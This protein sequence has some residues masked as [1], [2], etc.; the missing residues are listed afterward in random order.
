[1]IKYFKFLIPLVLIS[2]CTYSLAFSQQQNQQQLISSYD[3]IRKIAPREKLYV[4]LDKSVY[5]STDTIWFKAYLVNTTSNGYSPLSGLIYTELIDA[6]GTVIQTICLPTS[7]GLTWGAFAL[8]EERYPPGK[9][10]FR[11]YT[12][13][14]RNFGST[15][16]YKKEIKILATVV[17]STVSE[18]IK[19]KPVTVNQVK[20]NE[21]ISD[22]IDFQLLP[23]GGTWIAGMR[24]KMAFKAV[25]PNGK[26]LEASGEIVDSKANKVTGF[27]S[28]AKGM[29]AFV[30]VPNG[31]ENYT[32]RIK[33]RYGTII[34]SLP[35][36]QLIGT[37]LNV[38]T[39]PYSDSL[40]IT[41]ASNLAGQDHTLIG[42]SKGFICFIANLKSDGKLSTIK[43][44]K[45]IFPTGVS[46]V[47]VMNNKKQILNE[48]SFFINLGDEL[49]LKTWTVA[50]QFGTRDSIPIYLKATDHLGKP[51]QGSFSMAI[52]DDGQVLKD[53]LN[54]ANILSY[55][56]L[57]S[58][59][60]GDIE[61]PG[62]Y[63]HQPENRETLND[64]DLLMLTQGWVSYH[65]DL[66]KIPTFKAEQDFTI[67]GS[68]TNVTNKPIAGAKVSLFGRNK[69]AIVMKD[70]VANAK[71][72]F[73]FDQF[74]L[75]DSASFV[76]QALNS[77]NKKGTLGITANEFTSPQ[78][79]PIN[80]SKWIKDQPLD[81]ISSQVVVV[82]NE[83]YQIAL[84]SGIALRE[85]KIVGKKT[86]KGS[87]NLH[88]PGTASQILTEEDL[89]P[90]A[91]KT[92]YDVL[93]EKIKG[94]REGTRPRSFVRDFLVNGDLARFVIDGVEVD[95][96]YS[97]TGNSTDEYYQYIRSYLDYYNAEDIKGIE[98]MENG[99]SFRYRSEFMHP[100][101]NNMYAFFEI[102][103]KTGSGPF[104]KKSANMYLIKPPAYGSNKVFYSPKYNHHNKANQTPDFR[105]TLYWNPNIITNEKG[106][107]NIS[108]FSA[109]KKG[110]YTVWLEGV[111][112]QG[113][114]GV[115]TM[116]IV[117][118]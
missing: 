37:A 60:K 57:S 118:K 53:T 10:T 65:W 27:S 17:G 97:P 39:Q 24:Q 115:S 92:L 36:T 9:Y 47:L 8:N 96:F 78:F 46:Q 45:H 95:F 29:G 26:G 75:L 117:I 112:T 68:I 42:Q 102:T 87:K 111:D 51:V 25:S 50:S 43:V 12:N 63:F 110:T 84:K 62:Y 73:V 48:R 104:L 21:K 91:K 98:T 116:K 99:Y 58:D 76:I 82:K 113:G 34:K 15:Y 18:S 56:L 64:L 19:S 3:T 85:V 4:H 35:K 54:E 101:D 106:E 59:L 105:S 13:W 77:K 38:N 108:F 55:L 52:T 81:S 30:M 32:A 2:I 74:P 11:A 114:L 100:L 1:M 61:D 79:V 5:L 86:I 70:T 7:L 94:F 31:E 33:T 80:E 93:Y 22:E 28:N 20:L 16:V 107:A 83:A 6:K 90:L 72:E 66:T 40:T 44:S 49:K 14:M 71:G 41:L 103:T 89:A 23:E 67:H 109:D 88:G 69:S